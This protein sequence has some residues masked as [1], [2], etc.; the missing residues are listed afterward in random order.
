MSAEKTKGERTCALCKEQ[1]AKSELFRIVRT[2]SG[3]IVFDASGRKPG[4][5]AYVCSLACLHDAKKTNKL[6]RALKCKVSEQTYDK[7]AKAIELEQK[8]VSEIS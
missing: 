6:A 5:G 8:S 2:S 4:R 3:E 7:I 1:S